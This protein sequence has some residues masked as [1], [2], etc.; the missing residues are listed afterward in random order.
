V[1]INTRLTPDE[2]EG[3]LLAAGAT[4]ILRLSRGADFDR[5]EQIHQGAPFA[6]LKYGVGENRFVFSKAN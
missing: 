6:R 4:D 2:V 5:I 1:P 3:Y